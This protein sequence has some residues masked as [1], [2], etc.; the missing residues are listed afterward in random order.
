MAHRSARCRSR[1]LAAPRRSYRTRCT[2]RRLPPPRR[3]A[4][5]ASHSPLLAIWLFGVGRNLDLDHLVRVLDR[6]AFLDLVDHVHAGR[7]LTNHRVLPVEARRLA[8][9]DE[10]LAVGR[11][12]VAA[13]A[14]HA[15]DAALER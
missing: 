10:E 8:I 13:L 15:D 14:R 1:R 12:V 2:R 4:S 5:G 6:L 11:I 7:D 3:N 9:H